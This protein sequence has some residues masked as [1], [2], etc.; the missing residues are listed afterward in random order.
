A[1]G[2]VSIFETRTLAA[3]YQPIIA[4][5]FLRTSWYDAD[6]APGSGALYR[7]KSAP[8]LDAP[9]DFTLTTI[10]G[11]PVRYGLAEKRVTPTMFG[12][13]GNNAL[14]GPA[15]VNNDTA[16]FQAAF[17]LGRPIYVPVTD[18]AYV[19]SAVTGTKPIVMTS[20]YATIRLGT[21]LAA[22]A[23]TILMRQA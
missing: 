10:G 13:K 23:N 20:D 3:A 5:P 18:G 9:G 11:T 6:R 21:G 8:E 16:A 1:L 19:V 15:V 7:K 2:S 12:A 4:P 22:G 14:V 17:D